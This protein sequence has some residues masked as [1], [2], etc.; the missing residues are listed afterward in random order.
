MGLLALALAGEGEGELNR[1]QDI[2]PAHFHRTN[3][4]SR[5]LWQYIRHFRLKMMQCK[6]GARRD[7]RIIDPTQ[8]QHWIMFETME[9]M[10]AASVCLFVSH[11]LCFLRHPFLRP[12]SL[13]PVVIQPPIGR[14]VSLMAIDSD[15]AIWPKY[16]ALYYEPYHLHLHKLIFIFT[17]S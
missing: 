16:A 7:P 2:P 1:S 12:F 4:G 17:R 11:S 15:S 10:A 8:W 13:T 5:D 9:L 6:I 3:D 14:A